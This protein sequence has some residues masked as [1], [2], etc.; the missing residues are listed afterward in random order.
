MGCI[1]LDED[2]ET[3]GAGDAALAVPR[4]VL[5]LLARSA[6]PSLSPRFD[7]TSERVEGAC[8]NGIS[9]RG[10]VGAADSV[11]AIITMPATSRC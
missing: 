3:D 8:T 1:A 5:R 9:T 7:G 2:N 11:G 6:T 10:S 4:P